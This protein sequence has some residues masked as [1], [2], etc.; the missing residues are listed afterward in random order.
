MRVRQ[1]NDLVHW[2]RFFLTGVAETATKGRDVFQR[3]LVLRN[4]AEQ[5]VL[6]LGKRAPNAR[7]AL[8]FLYQ[9][10]VATA[11]DL[12]A[13][14]DITSPTANTLLRELERLGIVK[15]ATGRHWG[16]AYAFDRYIALFTM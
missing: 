10:P 3:I 1:S 13:A 14:L 9:K 2:V 16:R 8:D 7:A 15:E 5:A 4:E 11:A 6:T 12:Q